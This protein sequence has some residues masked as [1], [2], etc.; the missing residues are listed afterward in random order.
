MKA[1][2]KTKQ[3]KIT[4]RL[5]ELERLGFS[6]QFVKIQSDN[7]QLNLQVID[8]QLPEIISHLIYTKFKTGK[9]KMTD[10]VSEIIK[11]NPLK[12]MLSSGHP[13]YEY[14]IMNFLT[15][16][17]LGMTPEVVWTGKYD[18][19]GGIIIVKKDGDLVC[20]HIYNKN[21]FQAY[22]VNNTKLDQPSTSEDSTNPGFERPNNSRPR[23]KPYKYG[24]VYEEDGE[25]YIKLNL[26]IRFK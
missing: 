4:L 16:S 9:S 23:P 3:S 11:L 19:T 8:S 6:V 24:W 12:F 2:E 13:F 15:E 26:Q 10:L 25:F 22:L 17:A 5:N 1:T 18:A 20:Y 21:E 14:K 7:L